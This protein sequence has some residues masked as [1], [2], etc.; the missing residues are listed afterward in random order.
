[1]SNAT[2]GFNARLATIAAGYG[3]TAFTISW[4]AAS[5][6]FFQGYLDPAQLERSQLATFPAVALYTSLAEDAVEG[7]HFR[8]FAGPITAHVDFYRVSKAGIEV[9]DTESWADAVED[10]V[11]LALNDPVTGI[12]G[13]AGIAYKGE[14]R[15]PRESIQLLGEGWSQR[16]PIEI[17]CEVQA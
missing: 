16:V 2:T 13:Q 1:M 17:I 6:Q 5:K 4:L 15:S 12:Y 7:Q 3:V 10:A 14:F 11:I 8:L 9:D